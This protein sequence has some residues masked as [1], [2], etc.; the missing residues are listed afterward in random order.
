MHTNGQGVT[1]DHKEALRLYQ[2]AGVPLNAQYI[3]DKAREEEENAEIKA[4]QI[5]MAK[6]TQMERGSEDSCRRII[7]DKN[8]KYLSLQDP[9]DAKL[10]CQFGGVLNLSDMKAA[11]WIVISKQKDD[12]G[13]VYEY[14]LRKAR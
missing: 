2:L 3:T 6:V 14:L 10:S 4:R 7:K 12:E 1:K 11:G 13:I 5:V 9:T 8:E